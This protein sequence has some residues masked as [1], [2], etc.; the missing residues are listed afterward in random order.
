MIRG[1]STTVASAPSFDP[2]GD[3]IID[4]ADIF[5]L[6]AYLFTGGPG[7]VGGAGDANGDS[8]VDPSDIFYAVHYL[9]SGG[10]APLARTPHAPQT[11]SIAK[12]LSGALTLGRAERRDGRWFVPVVMTTDAAPKFRSRSH[13]ACSS[14]AR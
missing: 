1:I 10:P 3:S 12:P 2:N 7:P 6:V 5:Y 8:A 14:A 9:F 4:P 13:S 11:A